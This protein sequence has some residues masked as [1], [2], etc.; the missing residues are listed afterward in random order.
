MV[1]KIT[2]DTAAQKLAREARN[3]LSNYCFSECKALCCRQGH[4]LL[5]AKE[6]DTVMKTDK[7]E[8]RVLKT[9]NSAGASEKKYVLDLG[10]NDKACPNLLNLKCIE[11]K[12]PERPAACQEF[13]LFI[14]EGKKIMVSFTCP[15]AKENK[16]YPYLAKFKKM[17]YEITYGHE[18]NKI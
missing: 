4:L 13:P 10:R 12:N 14:R 11:H 18:N 8:L 6:A 16:L 5:T 3:S 1:S 15:A 17:G 2:E 7:G 9:Y